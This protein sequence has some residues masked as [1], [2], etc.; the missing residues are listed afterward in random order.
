M[1]FIIK[2]AFKT[3]QRCRA[4]YSDRQYVP[5]S[6]SNTGEEAATIGLEVKRL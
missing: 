3:V 2:L 5:E 4:L 6:R 1:N